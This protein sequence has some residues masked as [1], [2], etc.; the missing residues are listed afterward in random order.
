M[1]GSLSF[2][3]ELSLNNHYQE[4]NHNMNNNVKSIDML[5]SRQ[6][7][8]YL[9]EPAPNA[10]DLDL[11]LKSGMRVPDHGGLLP[12]LFTIVAGDGLERLS[13]LFVSVVTHVD[14]KDT[15]DEVTL[16]KV[17]KMPYRAPMII[18]ISTQYQEHKVPKQEQLITAGCCVHAMQ[19]AA[20]TLGYGAVWRTGELA[21]N[22]KI[23]Q[24]LTLKVTDDIVGFL[25]I[26]TTSKTLPT[27]PS[28][29]YKDLVRYF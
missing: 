29:S 7:N 26:G 20:F 10:D 4:I 14:E 3:V 21:Y 11:I 9:I 27:K 25:Y 1:F 18:V 23:K 28:K 22:D 16:A 8:P 15:V 13:D 19:M 5:L 12:W 17:K 24:G 2:H 6:S